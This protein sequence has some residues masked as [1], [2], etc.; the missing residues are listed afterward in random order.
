MPHHLPGKFVG[1]PSLN[2]LLGY[3]V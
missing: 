2:V 1:R 3:W